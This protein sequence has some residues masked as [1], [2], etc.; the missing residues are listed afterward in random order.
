MNALRRWWKN[1]KAEIER[2]HYLEARGRF[3]AARAQHYR[4]LTRP[5]GYVVE[6][7]EDEED[8]QVS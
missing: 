5:P 4:P 8:L 1:L 6:K 3:E 7:S 2:T